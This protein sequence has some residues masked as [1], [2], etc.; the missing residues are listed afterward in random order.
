[1]REIGREREKERGG[2]GEREKKR[3]DHG[4]IASTGGTQREIFKPSHSHIANNTIYCR[5]KLAWSTIHCRNRIGRKRD[6]NEM[7]QQTIP[8]LAAYTNETLQSVTRAVNHMIK[9]KTEISSDNSRH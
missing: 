1:M 4:G 2:E 8:T 5:Y 6:A 3:E 7:P 9:K